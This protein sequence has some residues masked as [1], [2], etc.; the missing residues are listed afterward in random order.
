MANNSRKSVLK[1]VVE[2]PYLVYRRMA[3]RGLTNWV[4]DE[5]HL[6][7]MYRAEL[8]TWPNL[9][10][11]KEFNEK[12]QWLK[13]HDRNPLY[14]TLVDKF[15]VKR[16]VADRIGPEHVT[17]TYATWR[18]AEDI[19]ISNLPERFVLKT[20][21][22]CGGVAICR[23][24]AVFDLDAAK[25]EL[26]KHLKTNYYWRTREWPYKD[27]MPCVFA[28]EYLDPAEGEDLYDYKLFRF[29]GGRLVTLVVTDRFTGGAL[30]KTFFDDEWHALPISEG[31]HPMWPKLGRPAAFE[32]MKAMA[33]RL[34]EE[35]PFVRVDFY[36]SAGNL[37]FGEMTFYPN[38]GFGRFEPS[39]WDRKFGDWI[40]L[41]KVRGGWLLVSDSW[42]LW[43]HAGSV[44]E[45]CPADYKVS[46]F[47]GEPRLIEVHKGR[48]TNHTCDY[49]TPEWRPLPDIE[50]AGLP[51]SEEG[52]EAPACL[53]KMLRFSSILTDGFPQARADWYVVGDRML[54]GELTLFNDAGFGLMDERTAQTLGSWIDL[55]LAYDNIRLQK[56]A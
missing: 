31:G 16:W 15:R 38:S 21:H 10:S 6:K 37:Y 17:K 27:V 34:G 9:K 18:R 47:G 40:D 50:W 39:E 48:S 2:N 45:S 26:S 32:Q 52:T 44:T 5:L 35:F 28:E 41:E 12:L 49:Y 55:G 22:D 3:A 1:R 43:A 25:E 30:S 54:F 7:M 36:E 13:L 14:T 24:R 8:G 20:N 4:P 46:C 33:D 19:D 56:D 53:D 11:P 29:S 42:A 51:K 23:D